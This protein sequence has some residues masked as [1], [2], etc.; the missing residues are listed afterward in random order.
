ML[1]LVLVLV[2]SLLAAMMATGSVFVLGQML[3]NQ[4]WEEGFYGQSGLAT[5]TYLATSVAMLAL[6]AFLPL[7]GVAWLRGWRVAGALLAGW[8]TFL[9]F[10]PAYLLGVL[11]LVVVLMDAWAR[12]PR[13]LDPAAS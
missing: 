5:Q 3:L 8:G 11:T 6:S 13:P 1:R 7:T 12:R 10:T 9:L 2:H 4:A